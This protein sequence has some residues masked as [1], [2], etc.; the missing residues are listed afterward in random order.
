MDSAGASRSWGQKS[1]TSETV[2]PEAAPSVE[3]DGEQAPGLGIGFDVEGEDAEVR[4]PV[5]GGELR[6]VEG[7]QPAPTALDV[8]QDLEGAAQASLDQVVHGE[9]HV[10]LVAD[11]ALLRQALPELARV[12]GHP[13]VDPGCRPAV[14]GGL[15]GGGDPAGTEERGPVHVF[16]RDVEMGLV[17][18]VG[19]EERF[20]VLQPPIEVDD[21]ASPSDAVGGLYDEAAETHVGGSL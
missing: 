1:R 15:A 5:A 21:G 20:A 9:A 18:I 3:G 19:D 11:D 4:R 6:V 2:S 8:A 7:P 17:A 10:G 16:R 13:D 14:E 12:L